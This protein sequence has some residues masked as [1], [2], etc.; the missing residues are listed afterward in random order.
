[1]V[2]LRVYRSTVL[3]IDINGIIFCSSQKLVTAPDLYT[4]WDGCTVRRHWL[5]SKHCLHW[6]SRSSYMYC[7][8]YFI[9]SFV[10]YLNSLLHTVE[11]EVRHPWIKSRYNSK[12]W[13]AQWPVLLIM[14]SDILV[15]L[16]NDWNMNQYME[17]TGTVQYFDHYNKDRYACT[18]YLYALGYTV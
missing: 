3:F 12:P 16:C 18:E 2:I 15:F 5:K 13:W 11:L 6:V 10:I 9:W 17:W 7:Y 1:M 8:C 4:A 14:R